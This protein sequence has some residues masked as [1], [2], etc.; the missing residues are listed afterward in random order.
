MNEKVILEQTMQ[1]FKTLRT[2]AFK[3]IWENLK[4]LRT[5]FVRNIASSE[6]RFLSFM[7]DFRNIF[8]SVFEQVRTYEWFIEVECSLK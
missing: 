5:Y 8:G 2:K 3:N 6:D 4:D 1:E 7:Y